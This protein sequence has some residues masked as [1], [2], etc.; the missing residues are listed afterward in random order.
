MKKTSRG[1]NTVN[2]KIIISLI[3]AFVMW[4]YVI[5]DQDPKNSQRYNNIDVK[6]RNEQVLEDKGLVL[7]NVLETS[8]DIT[9]SGRTSVLYNLPWRN[10]SAY[11]DLS[12]V[13]EKGS[14]ELSVAIQGIP[15]TVDL[16][17]VSPATITVEIDRITQ[18]NREIQVDFVGELPQ[19]LQL[20]DHTVNPGTVVVEGGENVLA[21]IQKVGGTIDMSEREEGFSEV[22]TLRAYDDQGQEV[23]GITL[24]PAEVT[25]TAAI[26]N[27]YLLP[28]E[29]IVTG[30]PAEGFQIKEIQMT[31]ANVAIISQGPTPVEKIETE[32]INIEGIQEDAEVTAKLIIPNGLISASDLET[33]QIKILV[34]PIETREFSVSTLEYRNR[35]E[36]LEV[37]SSQ[38]EQNVVV[39]LSGG[40]SIIQ[41]LGQN[42]IQLYVDLTDAVVGENQV[43][44]QMDE[45]EG[46]TLEELEPTQWRVVLE[47]APEEVEEE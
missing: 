45:L 17:N 47:E 20:T 16:E 14:Y 46:I 24:D 44:L 7:A 6:I 10:F 9:I 43:T 31:P 29:A 12:S 39:Q 40:K 25:V 36:G 18:Q 1:S 33:V 4:I 38:G 28:V 5:G 34:E 21:R 11:V 32:P 23:T 27:N 37:A 2:V 22:L 15:D 8:V 19:G 13:T 35:P 30:T 42:Q 3:V 41:A 26:G